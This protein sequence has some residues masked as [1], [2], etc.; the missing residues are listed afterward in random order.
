MLLLVL[1]RV[2]SATG[3]LDPDVLAS[4]GTIAHAGADLMIGASNEQSGFEAPC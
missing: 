1:W 3:V 4:P 2:F